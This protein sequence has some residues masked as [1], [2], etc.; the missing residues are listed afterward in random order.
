[1]KLTKVDVSLFLAKEL[2][3]FLSAYS[4]LQSSLMLMAD[5]CKIEVIQACLDEL[6]TTIATDIGLGP[7]GST[8]LE[9]VDEKLRIAGGLTMLLL[10]SLLEPEVLEDVQNQLERLANAQKEQLRSLSQSAGVN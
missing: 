10:G 8:S 7:G 3:V 2:E 6:V 9:Q 4:C 1:M 5:A